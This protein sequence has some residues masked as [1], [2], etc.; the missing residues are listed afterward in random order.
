MSTTSMGS[1]AGK[2]FPVGKGNKEKR[3]S[4]VA[5]DNPDTFNATN[6][7]KQFVGK[8]GTPSGPFGLKGREF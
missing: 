5:K 1:L 7:Q 4:T 2:N 8:K 6:D 3:L